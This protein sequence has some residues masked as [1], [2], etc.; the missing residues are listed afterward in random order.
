MLVVVAVVDE[1]FLGGVDDDDGT[2]GKRKSKLKKNECIQN[3]IVY[4]EVQIV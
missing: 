1:S 3:L 2:V 4:F